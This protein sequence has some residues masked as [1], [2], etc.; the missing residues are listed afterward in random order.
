MEISFIDSVTKYITRQFDDLQELEIIVPN[1]RTGSALLASLKRNATEICWAPKITPIKDIFI[2]NSNIHEAERIILVYNL[3]KAYEKYFPE[4][5]SLDKFYNLG[6]VLLSDFD[7][8]D[9]YLVDPQKLFKNIADESEIRMEFSEFDDNEKLIGILREFWTNVSAQNLKDGKLKTL[10]LWQNMPDVYNDFTQLLLEKGIGYQG[11]IYR[12]FVENK[13]E[14]VDFPFKNYAFVGFSALNKCEKKLMEHVRE[15]AKA[16]NGECLFFWDAD[17]Y[18]INNKSQEAGL[19]LRDN[20]RK[21]PLPKGF[22]LTDQIR[23]LNSR[24]V[25]IIE[26]PTSV[27]QVKLIPELLE[28][29][30][31]IDSRTAIILGDEKLLVPLIYSL[32]ETLKDENGNTIRRPYNIT[33]G[34]PLSYTA[35]ASFA[36]SVMMLA[37]HAST[38]EKTYVRKQDVFS[39]IT[40]SFIRR[41]SNDEMLDT[42]NKNKIEYIS[43]DKLKPYTEENV[44]LNTILDIN[45]KDKTFPQYVIDVCNTVYI[46]I[47]NDKLYSTESDFMHKIITLFTSFINAIGDEIRFENNKMYY[48]LMVS[49]IKQSNMAFDGKSDDCMQILGFM[50]TRSLDFDNVIMLSMNENTFPKSTYKQ[51][52]IP[53]GLRKAFDMPSIEFQDSIFAYYFYRLLQRSSKIRMIY[54]SEEKNSNSEKSRFLTQTEYELGLYE[55]NTKNAKYHETRSY[56]ILPSQN[57]KIEVKKTDH[58][59]SKIKVLLGIDKEKDEKKGAAPSMINTYIECPLKFNFKYIEGMKEPNGIDDDTSALDFGNLLHQSLFHLYHNYI[60]KIINKSDFKNIAGNSNIDKAIEYATCKVF[61]ID[62][63]DKKLVEE[64]KSKLMIKPLR[65]YLDK[66]LKADEEYAPFSI[67][68]LETNFSIEYEVEKQNVMLRGVIDRIDLKEGVLRVIDYKTSNIDDKTKNK[69]YNEKFWDSTN[70][71][72]KEAAQI[73]IYSEM[74]ARLKHEYIVVPYIISVNNINDGW[75]KCYKFDEN[76]KIK[77]CNIEN[78]Q[79]QTIIINETTTEEI[80]GE[81]QV[82]TEKKT[83][84]LRD[85]FNKNLKKILSKLLDINENLTQ[86]DNIETCKFCPYKKICERDNNK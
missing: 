66:I 8:I 37:M 22:E 35:S 76:N 31:E 69:T 52:M 75:L 2:K 81:Q 60:G 10:E 74:M 1:N 85:D 58:T 34:Y 71:K 12:N 54:S 73:L 82:K 33:M 29:C 26:V 67:I 47:L 18:Y 84:S 41:Y 20:I 25:K 45:L 14:S 79:G 56:E 30:K 24:D 39:V 63:N 48:K 40:N 64:A 61:E 62:E 19:F 9:K 86:T 16:K 4:H 27:A 50:E 38:G 49:M 53:Y 59:I 3:H 65:K 13:M 11:L 42:I 21:F 7:D 6:E 51:S 83:V 5:T 80:D 70:Y 78:Y 17:K 55:S 46:N 57:N 32:P 44:V 68:A 36:M 15:V 23:N 28:T 72:S 77:K 43:I